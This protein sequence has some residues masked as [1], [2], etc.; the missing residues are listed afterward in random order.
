MGDRLPGPEPA[1]RAVS[2]Q[3]RRPARQPSGGWV[4][5]LQLRLFRSVVVGEREP[6]EGDE[7]GIG[8]PELGVAR[9]LAIRL[10]Q[11]IEALTK[12]LE[13]GRRH[14]AARVAEVRE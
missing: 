12:V 13:L 6:D 5:L 3:R 10:E 9:P 7:P 11:L 2:E 4:S 1:E 8:W 14:V